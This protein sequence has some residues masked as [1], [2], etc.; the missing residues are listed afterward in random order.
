METLAVLV[1]TKGM[2]MKMEIHWI[3]TANVTFIYSALSVF[4]RGQ[5]LIDFGVATHRVATCRVAT[6]HDASRR[7]AT[8]HVASRHVAKRRDAL[9]REVFESFCEVLGRKRP[10]KCSG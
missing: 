5:L 10:Q 8:R 7:V 9:R 2:M 3:R 1:Q 6:R 4:G